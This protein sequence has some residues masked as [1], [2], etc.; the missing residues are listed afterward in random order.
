MAGSGGTLWRVL[1]ILLAPDRSDV[2]IV[3]SAPH[4]FIAAAVDEVG[5]EYPLAIADER[6]RAVPLVHAEV[7]VEAVGS[8]IITTPISH[9]QNDTKLCIAAQHSLVSLRRFFER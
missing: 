5:A 9:R 3:P 8:R 7:R 4:L 6:V 2:K 1:P